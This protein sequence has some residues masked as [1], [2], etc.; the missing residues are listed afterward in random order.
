[1]CPAPPSGNVVW[2]DADSAQ[3]A[4]LGVGTRPV[5]LARELEGEGEMEVEE[6]G[7][8]GG[9]DEPTSNLEPTQGK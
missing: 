2:D 4:L 7:T 8:E 3:R 6:K 5:V 9:Q 1:M